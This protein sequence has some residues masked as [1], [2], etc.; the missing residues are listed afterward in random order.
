MLAASV[1]AGLVAAAPAIAYVCHP[2]RAGTRVMSLHGVVQIQAM[3]GTHVTLAERRAGS[4]RRIVWDTS[5]GSRSSVSSCAGR[6]LAARESVVS[7]AGY[8]ARIEGEFVAIYRRGLLV[9]RIFIGYSPPPLRAISSG[10]GVYVLTS[11][12]ANGPA[13]L[14]GFD[15]RTGLKR[16]DYPIPYSGSSLDVAAGIAI[17]A[18][19]GN[20]GLYGLRLADGRIAFLGVERPRDNPQIEGPGIVYRDNLHHLVKAGTTTVKFVPIAAVRKDLARV[21][22]PLRTPGRIRAFSMDGPRVSLAVAG[23]GR[24]CDRILHW[25]I[26]WSYSSFITQ[27]GQHEATCPNGQTRVGNVTSLALGGLGSAWVLRG[28]NGSALVRE[29]SVA[30]VERILAKGETPL[31]AADKGL[32][33][34]VRRAGSRWT[35]SSA[36][37]S[38][39]QRI[40]SSSVAPRAL[41]VDGDRVALLRVDD[42][43]EIWSRWGSLLAT[44]AVPGASSFALNGG[45][46]TVLTRS[47]TLEVFDARTGRLQ[48]SWRLPSGMRGPVDVQYGVAVLTRG[49]SVFGIRLATGRM[50]ALAHGPRLMRAQIEAPGVAYQYNARG[51]GFVGFVP[52]ARIEQR[53]G[54]L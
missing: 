31:V 11:P 5:T 26:P 39:S 28:P 52:L 44:V 10:T 17:F 49:A 1:V 15:A 13:R 42:T 14:M 20:S 33:A 8:Q 3:R 51:R 46:L 25:N 45:A 18:T 21:G 24:R 2:D 50:A 29:N 53:L 54:R 4:C 7:R 12:A 37:W 22:H 43:I 40:G 9:H 27:P 36:G 38:A 47:H 41:S 16:V 34:Y 35:I 6:G 23:L 48:H 19:T 30:C 32:I